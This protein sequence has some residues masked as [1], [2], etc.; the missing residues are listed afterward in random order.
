VVFANLLGVPGDLAEGTMSNRALFLL[1]PALVLQAQ[2]SDIPN[3]VEVRSG[4]FVLRGLPNDNTCA[5]IKKY[6]ITHVIDFRRDGEP[7][8]DCESEASRLQE[9]GVAYQ[10]YA[11]G[12]VPPAND[13]DFIRGILRDLPPRSKVLLHCNN[14]NRAAAMVT[15]WL[16]LDK[17]MPVVEAMRLAKLSGLQVPE[18][19]EAVRR[20]LASKGRS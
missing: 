20:Y 14:G 12:K 18:T 15:P 17:G 13:M 6:R 4:V 9:M 5:A 1:L 8:L 3:A 7:N 2:E 16:V 19:E 10:R 11:V